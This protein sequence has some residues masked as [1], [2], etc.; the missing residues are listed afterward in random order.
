MEAAESPESRIHLP[1]G[2]GGG[3]SFARTL[4]SEQVLKPA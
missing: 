1:L 3:I 2:G 4:F